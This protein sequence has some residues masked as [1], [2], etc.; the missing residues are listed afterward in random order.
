MTFGT[1]FGSILFGSIGLGA[2]IYGKKQGQ[3]RPLAV[4]I[5]LMVFPYFVTK[6]WLMY[7]VGALIT[8]L[9]FF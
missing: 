7:L 4:G 6:A 8:V 3:A 9:L 2:F 5:A 1:L